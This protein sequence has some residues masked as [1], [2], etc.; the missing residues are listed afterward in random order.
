MNPTLEY[1]FK[2]R[3]GIVRGDAAYD[4]KAWRYVGGHLR[5]I[6]AVD[7]NLRRGGKKK[8]ADREAMKRGNNQS[9]SEEE[10]S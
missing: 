6:W 3:V 7:Y 9:L 10:N 2:F 8:L 5:A 4:T 1:F